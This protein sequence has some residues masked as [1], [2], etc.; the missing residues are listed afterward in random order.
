M[1]EDGAENCNK[2]ETIEGVKY[3]AKGKL[4]VKEKSCH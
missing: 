2:F 1:Q 3:K 4:K